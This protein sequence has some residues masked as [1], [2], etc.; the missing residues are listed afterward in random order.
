MTKTGQ[1][2]VTDF[3]ALL[4]GTPLATEIGGRI[5]RAG[6][7]PRDSRAEDLVVIYTTA[8]AE[9]FQEGVVTLNIFVPDIPT[10]EN[11]VLLQD[12][13]R[14][15]VLEGVAQES[16]EML[17]AEKSDY[18]IRLRDAISTLRDEEIGQSFVSVSIRFTYKN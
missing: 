12:S 4:R 2:I 11:G 13:A 14:C 5:Y 8:N 15:E 3:I 7:R 18:R 6:T 9:Q 16:V 17:S 10:P 1:Q